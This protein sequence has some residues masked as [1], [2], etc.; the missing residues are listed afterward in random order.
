M[1]KKFSSKDL[2]VIAL[3][4][5]LI[6]S[7]NLLVGVGLIAATG[8][9]LAGGLVT[10][11][12]TVFIIAVPAL[13]IRKFGF[14]TLVLVIHGALSTPTINVGPP[15]AYKILVLLVL[16][17]IMDFILVIG[18]YKTWS[19]YVGAGIGT[20]ALVPFMLWMM[21]LLGLP[22]ADRLAGFLFPF[23]GIYLVEALLG[24]WLARLTYN[25]KFKNSRLARMLQ[26]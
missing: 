15:G 21:T 3:T 1:F 22:S 9:S 24:M 7:V 10:V 6:F 17:L 8:T 18:K 19:W 11:V 14:I 16:G 5:A 20:A 2:I 4:A 25:K 26:A 13:I 12:I 23:M